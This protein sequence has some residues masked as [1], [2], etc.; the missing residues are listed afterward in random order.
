MSTYYV[1]TWDHEI[2]KFTPQRGV[3]A[4]PYSKWELREA[5]RKLRT[6]GYDVSRSGGVNVLVER[7]DEP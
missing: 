3:Q 6:M 1:T 5:L 7:R 4:G 2:E